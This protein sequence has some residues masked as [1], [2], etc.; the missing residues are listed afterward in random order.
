MNKYRILFLLLVPALLYAGVTGKVAGTI[1]DAQTGE[2]LPGANIQIAGTSLGAV[3][4]IHGQYIILNVPPGVVAAKI[5]FVGYETQVVTNLRIMIDL[6]TNVTVKLRP[7]AVQMKEVVIIA[8]KPMIQKD[9][10]S[11]G[12]TMR[13]EEIASLPV[14]E[15][16]DVLAL[17]AG[18]TDMGGSLHLRGGRSNEVGFMI[19]GMYVQDPLLGRM[20]TQINNDA[21]QE[22]NLLSGTY[23]AEYGNA[24]SGI[25]N[26]VTRDGGDSHSGNLEYRSSQF[27]IGRFSDLEENRL[28]G[29]LGGPLFFKKLKYFITGEQ[30]HKGSYLP[31][32]YNLSKTLFGKL[33]Y[34]MTPKMK[35]TLSNRA[36]SSRY[37]RYSHAY[38]YIP[39]Q[40]LRNRTRT[41][42]T[43]LMVNQ[44]LKSNLFYDMRLSFLDEKYYSGIDKDTSSYLSA[45][46]AEYLPWAGDGYEFY[47]KSDYP[48]MF[49][50]HNKTADFKTDM[51]WQANKINE[52]KFGVQY[53]K[54][55]LKLFYVY[56]PKR[57][58]PYLNDYNIKPFEAAGYIQDKIEFPYLIINLGLRYDYFNANATFRE[59]PLS[60]DKLV[61]VKARTQISPRL[62][63]AHPVS[64]RTKIH[65]AYGHFFQNPEYQFLFENRQYD[66][67][68]REPLFGQ[69]NLDAQKTVA[70]EVGV[71]HQFSDRIAAH[72]TAHY[73][74]ITDYIGTKYYEAFSGNTGRFVGYTV[75]VN[76]DYANDKGFEINVE[77]RQGRY[78]GG[79]LSYTYSIAKGSASSEAEQYP[80]TDESTK[81]YYLDWDQRHNLSMQTY[82]RIPKDEGPLLFGKHL[83]ANTDY[84][85][86]LRAASGFPYTPSGRD[87]GFVD[88]NS[89]RRPGTYT[90]DLEVGKELAIG[91][92]IRL[93]AFAE[94]LNLTN[95]RNILYVYGDTGSPDFTLVGG[96]SNEYMR[97]PSNYG[98]PRS[99]RLGLGLQ[100]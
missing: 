75:Y 45:T 12:A 76:E 91:R 33:S 19:D 26:I 95:H 5:S 43:L 41:N 82:F 42:Q 77:V 54:H 69:A 56:D 3:S 27:G 31:F 57:N 67:N 88:K 18:V 78:F 96:Y 58:Y 17:Q 81:L 25:V 2:P 7:S 94:C 34:Q 55:W 13:R 53:R 59:D 64:D 83:L 14:T 61:T 39:D 89:L 47:A 63:I 62:G 86:V 93:R 35:F 44:S 23:N 38:K 4:D 99:I 92:G 100:R 98:P 9:L 80:G 11:S 73:K 24:L 49:D 52:V 79:G 50:N 97:D 84:S 65:F 10:T 74:D 66:L 30:N 36:A 60:Q 90:M 51:V 16:T 22:L 29:S 28:N 46:E 48:E 68:V 20:I 40:Y 8:D 6:T 1:T 85:V 32:G 15:F 87:I 71:S 72:L 37:Q 70:Y 21:I